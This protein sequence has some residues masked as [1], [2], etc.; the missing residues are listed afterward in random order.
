MPGRI[1]LRTTP[2]GS[3]AP[4]DAV[5]IDSAQNVTVSAGNLVQGTAAKG[6]NFTANTPAASMTSQLLNW[7]EEGTWTPVVTAGTG[8]I[9]SVSV[10]SA[11]YTRNGRIVFITYDFTI[12]NNGTGLG[13]VKVSGLPFN[14]NGRGFGLGTEAAVV[15]FLTAEQTINGG[16]YFNINKLDGTYPG[17]TNFQ[18]IGSLTYIV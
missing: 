17:G 14:S 7:Y 8:T 12:T 3:Q 5:K 9:T 6:V 4:V 13:F 1:L 16:D 15:G 18:L 11:T 10:T 2:D